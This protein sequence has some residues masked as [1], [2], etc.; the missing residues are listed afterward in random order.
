VLPQPVRVLVDSPCGPVIGASVVAS[1]RPG[2]LRVAVE[3]EPVPDTLD[4]AG[5]KPDVKTVTGDDGVAAFWWQPGFGDG[6][7]AVLD[8]LLAESNEPPV[9]VSAQLDPPGARTPGIHITRLRFGGGKQFLNDS[10]VAALDLAN[11]I[12]AELDG[13]VL[14]PSVNRKPVL[15]VEIDLP[16]PVPGE[17]NRLWANGPVG[18]RTVTLDSVVNSDNR[19]LVWSPSPR[20][21]DWLTV[22]LWAALD[23]AQWPDPILGRYVVE[24]WAI[25]ADTKDRDL[26]LNGHARAV[27][28][29]GRTDLVLPTDD[30]VPGGQ[31]VQWFRLSRQAKDLTVLQVPD[32]ARRT[33]VVARRIV[34][35]LGLTVADEIAEPHPEIRKGLV[36]RTD[37]PAGTELDPGG[38][39]TL[40]VSSGHD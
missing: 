7:S 3:G 6:R 34:E 29:G 10:D 19:V 4:G 8:V 20:S 22:G 33:P 12:F 37:P 11:G 31:F 40:V 15:R 18:Y 14:M 26:H 9:R 2:L 36:L 38:P 28:V 16:W 24:G 35:D 30:D 39:V 32:L 27:L 5:G 13:N 17:E 23:K 21:R 25:I 1:G